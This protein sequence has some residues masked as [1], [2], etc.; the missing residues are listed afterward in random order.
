MEILLAVLAVATRLFPHV[1]NFTAIGA[2]SLFLS[3][4]MGSKK[5]LFIMLL[6]MI[7]T[8]AYLGFSYVTIFVYLGM[9][10]YI[11]LAR[12]IGKNKLSYLYIPVIGS[13]IFFLITNFAVWTG[14]WY[15][16]S[17][18][19]LVS[20]FT[21]ALPFYRNT[22]ISDLG[23]SLAIFG[24]YYVYKKVKRRNL[25]WRRLLNPAISSQR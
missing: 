10:S 18:A 13:T 7:A 21:L 17:L 25:S 3:K 6:A 23:F 22:L 24:A 20:C 19:G 2:V 16:H 1:P 14:P 9:A 5:A 8:D 4:N 15:P 12:H 11:F